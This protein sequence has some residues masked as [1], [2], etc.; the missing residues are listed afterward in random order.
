MAA[1][2]AS[3]RKDE[4]DRAYP[5]LNEV[6]FDSERKRMSTIMDVV[7]PRQRRRQPI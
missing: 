1:A 5:R 2:K 4:L 6:P 7:Q 3:V